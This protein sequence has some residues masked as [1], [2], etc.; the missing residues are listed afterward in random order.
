MNAITLTPLDDTLAGA[1]AELVRGYDRKAYQYAVQGIDRAA[2]AEYH[3]AALHRE[4][5]RGG[6]LWVVVRGGEVVGV[7]G[8]KPHAWHSEVFGRRIWVVSP[9]LFGRATVKEVAAA[10]V[11]LGREVRRDGAELLSARVDMEDLACIQGAEAAGWISVGTSVKLSQAAPA[12]D[13]AGDTGYTAAVSS[14]VEIAELEGLTA[15]DERSLREVSQASHTHSHFFND[16]RLDR[17]AAQRLFEEWAIRCA[18]LGHATTLLARVDGR[19]VGFLNTLVNEAV[20]RYTGRVAGVIDFIAVAP[21]VQ[22]QGIGSRLVRA[23]LASLAKRADLVEVR[24]MLDNFRAI[25]LYQRL[26][27]VLVSADVHLHGWLAESEPAP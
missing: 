3:V 17:A 21:G 6:R 15:E 10:L 8:A 16:P 18:R 14:G 12:V 26:G 27:A 11:Q 9:L 1:A 25:R 23:A 2:L 24:T 13:V 22:G 7:C 4:R 5:E 20:A 19:C